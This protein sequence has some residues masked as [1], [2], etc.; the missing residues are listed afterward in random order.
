MVPRQR[1]LQQFVLAQGTGSTD[2]W[3][4]LDLSSEE[5]APCKR[6]ITFCV[7]A[8]AGDTPQEKIFF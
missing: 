6:C 3:A 2:R 5:A 8:I 7:R 1:L 4:K